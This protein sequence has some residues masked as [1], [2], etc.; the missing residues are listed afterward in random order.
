MSNIHHLRGAPTPLPQPVKKARGPYRKKV[1]AAEIERAVLTAE[2]VGLTIYGFTIDG[3]KV[4]FQTRPTPMT[5]DNS[6]SAVDAWFAS[7]LPA[8]RTCND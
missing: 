7:D 1:T 6:Q 5:A 4:H 2:K 3:D 8:G